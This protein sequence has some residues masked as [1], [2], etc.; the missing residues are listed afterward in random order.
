MQQLEK[1][2][3]KLLNAWAFYDWANSVYSLVISSSIFPLYFGFLFT[4]ENP[5]IELFGTSIKATSLVFFTTAFAFL[6]VAIVSPILS[7]IAEVIGA[8]D[9]LIDFTVAL[10]KLDKIG[11][12]GVV[13]E[14]KEKGISDGAIAELMPIIALD[15]DIWE[16]IN[17]LKI[18]LKNTAIGQAGLEELS[19]VFD[20]LKSFYE[21]QLLLL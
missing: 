6:T 2:N 19:K 17:R 14:L 9:K 16:K 1:G 12:D 7:G 3:S 13:K 8:S 21:Q 10:D 5:N 11:E 18:I 20:Y 15:G 4:K